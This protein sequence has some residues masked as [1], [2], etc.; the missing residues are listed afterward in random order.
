[1]PQCVREMERKNLAFEALRKLIN[2][3]VRSRSQRNVVQA[4]AF[5]DRLQEAIAR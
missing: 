5:S 4:K 3:E 2:G 1:M